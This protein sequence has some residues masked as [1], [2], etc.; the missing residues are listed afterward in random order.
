M[1]KA[2]SQTAVNPG[3]FPG[4]DTGILQYR[5]SGLGGKAGGGWELQGQW[6]PRTN[7]AILTT[8][9]LKRENDRSFCFLSWKKEERK[10]KKERRRV[11]VF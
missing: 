4:P 1:I 6:V 3:Q 11:G 7:P 8:H 9:R 5:P 10:E 2:I